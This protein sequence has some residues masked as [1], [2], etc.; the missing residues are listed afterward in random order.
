MTKFTANDGD[1]QITGVPG[2]EA[3]MSDMTPDTTASETILTTLSQEAVA[4]L[5]YLQGAYLAALLHHDVRGP[6]VS[7]TMGVI[8][9]LIVSGRSV[10]RDSQDDTISRTA[11]ALPD[12]GSFLA[13]LPKGILK[14]DDL[15]LLSV[16]S[17]LSK[18]GYWSPLADIVAGLYGEKKISLT[19]APLYTVDP[20]GSIHPAGKFKL[21]F[22]PAMGSDLPPFWD[23]LGALMPSIQSYEDVEGMAWLIS[24][25]ALPMAP[26]PGLKTV[27]EIP[28][29]NY[30]SISLT[31]MAMMGSSARNATRTFVSKEAFIDMVRAR[32]FNGQN[33]VIAGTPFAERLTE[34]INGISKDACRDTF[35]ATMVFRHLLSTT[36]YECERKT[37]ID[38]ARDSM[39]NSLEM[40]TAALEAFG[41][42]DEYNVENSSP[43]DK[44]VGAGAGSANDTMANP[45][46][47]RNSMDLVS[48][49]QGQD[50]INDH[51]YRRA[52]DALNHELQ[53]NP[54][55]GIDPGKRVS[56]KRFCSMWLYLT[57][58]EYVRAFVK[59]L[60]LESAAL[61]PT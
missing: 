52:V 10:L 40:L 58:I 43:A 8:R 4:F 61:D 42:E 50:T 14:A 59:S 6:T 55:I 47:G 16:R 45:Q 25:L 46:G 48:I 49:L 33:L 35:P 18:N 32:F 22:N 27:Y 38:M 60:G 56:L 5:A 34:S 51:L 31:D 9:K 57:S 29:P 20:D 21:D 30:L 1:V 2:F 23:L 36:R 39:T 28:L 53:R 3:I 26:M 13:Y 54:E 15:K 7:L 12:I 24:K 19:D 41:D 11:A 44:N 37:L 17:G